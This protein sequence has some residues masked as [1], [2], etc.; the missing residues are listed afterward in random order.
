MLT[1]RIPMRQ[2]RQTLHLHYQVGLSY[3]QVGRALE[4]PKSTIGKIVSLARAVGIDWAL[5]QSLTDE[6]L[7]TVL[8]G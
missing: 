3:A 5:A 6:E 4:V 2:I 1:P 7:E 8:S